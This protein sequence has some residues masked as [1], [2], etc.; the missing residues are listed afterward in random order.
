[1]N[2]VTMWMPTDAAHLDEVLAV[3]HGQAAVVMRTTEPA[4][5]ANND[6][7]TAQ[8][9]I[10]VARAGVDLDVPAQARAFQLGALYVAQSLRVNPHMPPLDAAHALVAYA[11]RLAQGTP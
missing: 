3:A 8:L 9:R 2:T 10:H 5:V 11:A 4:L 6:Q 7:T 1:M